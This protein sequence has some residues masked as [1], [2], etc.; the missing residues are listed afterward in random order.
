MSWHVA[1][2]GKFT[3]AQGHVQPG[4]DY[5]W[6][7]LSSDF[8]RDLLDHIGLG[9][10]RNL[11]DVASWTNGSG[12]FFQW[13]LTAPNGRWCIR[14]IR[15]T[16]W[17]R[18]PGSRPYYRDT[19]YVLAESDW[20]R[21]DPCLDPCWFD[22]PPKWPALD[23]SLPVAKA[24]GCP[25]ECSA[26]MAHLLQLESGSVAELGPSMPESIG[27]LNALLHALPAQ[28]S[29]SLGVHLGSGSTEAPWDAQSGP[30]PP[31]A[32]AQFFDGLGSC[33]T[34]TDVHRICRPLRLP[35]PNPSVRDLV[36]S[37][38][39]ALRWLNGGAMPK[40]PRSMAE[41]FDLAESEQHLEI[42][43]T[44]LNQPPTGVPP[45][46]SPGGKALQ[47]LL[48]SNATP[49]QLQALTAWPLTSKWSHVA[50]QACR[51]EPSPS[52]IRSILNSPHVWCAD[53]VEK[54]ALELAIHWVNAESSASNPSHQVAESI[55]QGPLGGA[56]EVGPATV[57]FR[58]ESA[59]E[60]T[61]A[62]QSLQSHP[63]ALDLAT[64]GCLERGDVVGAC[65]LQGPPHQPVSVDWG[66]LNRDLA[67]LSSA[68]RA[69]AVDAALAI[70][71]NL[72]APDQVS[73]LL[74]FLAQNSSDRIGHVLTGA[75]GAGNQS[76]SSDAIQGSLQLGVVDH[77]AALNRVASQIQHAPAWPPQMTTMVL[78]LVDGNWDEISH[79]PPLAEIGRAI[80]TKKA[81]NLTQNQRL[82][83]QHAM[84]TS[85]EPLVLDPRDFDPEAL[86][87]IIQHPDAKVHA[88]KDE[89][90][91]VGII[92]ATGKPDLA[93]AWAEWSRNLPKRSDTW[94]LLVP[95]ECEL[96]KTR[97]AVLQSLSAKDLQRACR[98]YKGPLFRKWVSA[99]TAADLLEHRPEDA[100]DLATRMADAAPKQAAEADKVY[101]A[102]IRNPR[103]SQE[104][105]ARVNSLRPGTK[106]RGRGR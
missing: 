2:R 35:T 91:L 97:K 103:A 3:D 34:P 54:H 89:G 13:L 31:S 15:Q 70:A 40:D 51:S 79:I 90:A 25:I 4:S 37:R 44:L 80:A 57:F 11:Q 17:E 58:R 77:A 53:L 61:Q 96:T 26:T 36:K 19:F 21:Q 81:K 84:A 43:E 49:D 95:R 67:L 93:R 60:V 47:A 72:P 106:G 68:R 12:E 104:L 32:P 86:V 18:G 28:V 65:F 20:R 46:N 24:E 74:D 33:Q 88:G 52:L 66:A 48:N 78:C 82:V 30:T 29:F 23:E 1:H 9:F 6:I 62:V 55:Q 92:L 16:S 59:D 94:R 7:A 42:L 50:Q 83:W 101:D 41:A 99:W 64:K 71:T 8:P 87:D 98:I 102:I 10:G 105:L 73:M 38:L 39:M 5:D 56:P 63:V 69:D 76:W 45:A 100:F 85:G 75:P 27:R 14:Q 22:E